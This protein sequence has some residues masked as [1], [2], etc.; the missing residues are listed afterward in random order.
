MGT[1]TSEIVAGGSQS[2]ESDRRFGGPS[3]FGV[4]KSWPVGFFLPTAGLHESLLIG[5]NHA[6]F[7]GF[8]LLGFL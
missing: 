6:T 2:E 8:R 7:L 5:T 3:R 1:R 4:R